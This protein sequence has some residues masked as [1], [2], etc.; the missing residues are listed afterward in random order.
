MV[1]EDANLQSITVTFVEDSYIAGEDLLSYAGTTIQ[2]TFDA[3]TGSLVLT[4]TGTETE[5]LKALQAVRYESIGSTFTEGSRFLQITLQD[6]G[7]ENNTESTLFV[8]RKSSAIIDNSRPEFTLATSAISLPA[9]EEFVYIAED[10]T[11]KS[12]FSLILG[13]TVTISP[14]T[15]KAKMS[16]K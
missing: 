10:A 6:D 13:A 11:L 2:G 9:H 7:T 8:I 5:W 3:V 4:G 16:F 15:F 12:D 1:A 14:T